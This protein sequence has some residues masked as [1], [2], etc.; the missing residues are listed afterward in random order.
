MEKFSN[1]IVKISLFIVVQIMGVSQIGSH[2][3]VFVI[4]LK[5]A[6]SHTTSQKLPVRPKVLILPV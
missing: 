6:R 5:P 4:I 1:V 2:M 3:E